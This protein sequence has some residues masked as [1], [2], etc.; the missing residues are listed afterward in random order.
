MR[1]Y[2]DIPI[3]LIVTLA[4]TVIMLWPMEAPVPAPL[5]SDK[6]VHFTA[7]AALAFPL[8]R[9]GRF[10][11]LPVFIGAAA[12]GGLIEIIQPS[13]NRNAD[14]KDWVADIVGVVLGIGCGMQYRRLRRH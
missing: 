9:T 3:T 14:F 8:A 2:L 10:G 13:F 6:I 4:L 12:F 7:F 11:L 5:G 1:K